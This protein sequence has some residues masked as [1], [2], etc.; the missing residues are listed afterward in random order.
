MSLSIKHISAP[1]GLEKSILM[2]VVKK[3]RFYMVLQA[4]LSILSFVAFFPL[5][6]LLLQSFAKSNFYQYMS[7]LFS[8][9]IGT[10]WQELALSIVESMPILSIALFLSAGIVFVYSMNRAIRNRRHFLSLKLNA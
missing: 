7:L 9:E 5:G 3:E 8:S 6:S 10:Y 4:G 1:Q 2:I